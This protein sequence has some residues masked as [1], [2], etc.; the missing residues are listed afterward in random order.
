MQTSDLRTE[1]V[2]TALLPDVQVPEMAVALCSVLYS[3]SWAREG[4]AARKNGTS[5]ANNIILGVVSGGCVGAEA[6]TRTR[7]GENAEG[8]GDDGERKGGEEV[9]ALCAMTAGG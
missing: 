5:A 2:E 1:P 9:S 6:A 3:M 7:R 8:D 4:R